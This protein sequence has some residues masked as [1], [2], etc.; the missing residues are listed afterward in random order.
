MRDRLLPRLLPARAPRASSTRA[1]AP[2]PARSTSSSTRSTTGRA[3]APP[4]PT[5]RTTC[6]P[7]R[8]RPATWRSPR[9]RGTTR[10]WRPAPPA[11]AASPRARHAIAADAGARRA[12]RRSARAGPSPTR[13]RCANIVEVLRELG[14]ARS[15]EKAVRPLTGLKVACYYGCLLVRPP[16]VCG[17]D[18]PERRPRWRRSSR[19]TGATPVTWNMRARV[20][21]RRL[22]ALAHRL[23]GAARARDPRRRRA[24][25][26]PR[27]SWSP[28]RCATPTSTSGSRRS[29]SARRAPSC[30]SSSS[31]SSSASRSGSTPDA[32]GLQRHFV[33]HRGRSSRRSA[34]RPG[35]CP[36][37]GRRR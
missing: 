6:S 19:A 29:R 33:E 9:S 35:R 11:T 31:P 36:R 18:D 15:S 1:C 17:F 21:R 26:A 5:P 24:A 7:W 13:S 3:A 4:R 34:A 16:E 32:L 14:S 8:C 25:P 2:S 28:A 12:G 23:G 22:L 20:L 27:R 10:C 37:R 30:R